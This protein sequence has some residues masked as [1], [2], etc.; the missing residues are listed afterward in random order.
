M[1]I[2]GVLI[3]L[4]R[5]R[6]LCRADVLR[7][8]PLIIAVVALLALVPIALLFSY[9]RRIGQIATQAQRVAELQQRETDRNQQ[10]IMRLLDE[11]VESGGRRPDGSDHGHRGEHH[12]L[13]IADSVNYAVEALRKL[14]ATISR[15]GAFSSMAPHATDPG[16]GLAPGAGQQCPIQAD[17]FSDGIDRRDGLVRSR[18]SRQVPSVAP[19]WRATR[20]M[21]PTKVAT[22]FGARST[23]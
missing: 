18:K 17:R 19:M 15:V 14:V 20:S 6:L 1:A 8:S 9:L 5:D 13:A 11:D 16:A 7:I 23:A 2:A 12:R 4:G 3:A 10:A 22:Q 21:S